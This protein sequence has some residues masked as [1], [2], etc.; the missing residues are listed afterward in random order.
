MLLSPLTRIVTSLAQRGERR[1]TTIVSY[2][3]AFES[4]IV[5]LS[6][7]QRGIDMS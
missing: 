4:S 1:K 6:A 7:E 5:L 3:T 2:F